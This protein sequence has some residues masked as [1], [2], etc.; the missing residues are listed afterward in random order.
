MV[1]DRPTI[2]LVI[3][4]LSIVFGSLSLF[5]SL[6]GAL[7]PLILYNLPIPQPGGGTSYPVRELYDLLQREVPAY[8]G[9]EVGNFALGL[10]LAG[11]LIISG[12]GLLRMR[13]W[14]RWTSVIYGIATIVRSIAYFVFT[15]TII[16]PIA[17]RWSEDFLRRQ[18]KGTPNFSGNS[19][20]NAIVGSGQVLVSVAF[21]VVL[22]V[23]MFVPS[24]RAAFGRGTR[25]GKLQRNHDVQELDD[26]GR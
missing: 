7:V 16:N 9:V 24:V 1:Q 17:E 14:A 26:E 18:P 20:F 21:S 13:S 5:F 2:I 3:A 8:V 19:V 11:L 10:A 22:L 25:S 23:I 6:C 4:I 12:I 15:V